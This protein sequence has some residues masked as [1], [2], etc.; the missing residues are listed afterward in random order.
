[1][2][3]DDVYTDHGSAVKYEFLLG[4]IGVNLPSLKLHVA[5]TVI[6]HVTIR[7]S[8]VLFNL[9]SCSY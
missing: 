8:V 6:K 4:I 5:I 9:N 3:V 1:M 7:L 2:N